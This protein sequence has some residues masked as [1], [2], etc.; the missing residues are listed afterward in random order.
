M[1]VAHDTKLMEAKSARELKR[2]RISGIV[3]Q[4]MAGDLKPRSGVVLAAVAVAASSV[5]RLHFLFGLLDLL[6]LSAFSVAFFHHET[7]QLLGWVK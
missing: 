5:R 6:V 7:I 2:G 4:K 1:A 3:L